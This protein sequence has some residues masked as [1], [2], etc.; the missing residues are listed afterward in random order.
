MVQKSGEKTTWDIYIYINLVNNGEKPPRINW[1]A[2]LKLPPRNH[3]IVFFGFR[4]A[5]HEKQLA[6]KGFMTQ[7]MDASK[8]QP[9]NVYDKDH[10]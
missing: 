10:I 4:R 8:I 9:S 6:K 2:G 1:L 3:L 7:G 5:K